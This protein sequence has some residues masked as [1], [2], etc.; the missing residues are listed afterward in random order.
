MRIRT[1]DRL[2]L[3]EVHKVAVFPH[4]CTTVILD[5]EEFELGRYNSKQ[6]AIQVLDMMEMHLTKYEDSLPFQMPR[7]MDVKTMYETYF[8]KMDAKTI[9][10][11][12]EHVSPDI[13]ERVK[14]A[15]NEE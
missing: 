15:L 13:L 10:K 7:K 4:G 5:D 14:E 9:E 1:Q 8:P 3:K 2:Y 11:C 12:R 6:S